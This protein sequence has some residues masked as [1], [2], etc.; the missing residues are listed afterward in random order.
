M[1][2]LLIPLMA[3]GVMFIV[4]PFLALLP[5]SI[6]AWFYLKSR[7]WVVLIASFLWVLYTAYEYSMKLR[8]L[9]SGECNIRIDLVLIYPLLLL[10]SILA[11]MIIIKK[12]KVN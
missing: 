8:I 1:E 5:A 7:H 2:I 9:C 11:I 4:A 10:I 6:F 3:M 12:K